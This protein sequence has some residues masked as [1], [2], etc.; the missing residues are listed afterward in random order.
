MELCRQLRVPRRRIPGST[1]SLPIPTKVAAWPH[2]IPTSC[3]PTA[4]G[5]R[6][7]LGQELPATLPDHFRPDNFRNPAQLYYGRGA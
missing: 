6:D 1:I 2:I 3:G 4:T 5:W 7:F